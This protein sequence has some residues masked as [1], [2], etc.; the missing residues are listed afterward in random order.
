MA[1]HA[2]KLNDWTTDDAID[3]LKTIKFLTEYCE[4]FC[5]EKITGKTPELLSK[6]GSLNQELREIGVRKLGDRVFICDS[7]E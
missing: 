1:F 5:S 6:N 3:W 4:I 2:K 7:V